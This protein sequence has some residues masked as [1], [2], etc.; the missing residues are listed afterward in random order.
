MEYNNEQNQ[1]Q[2]DELFRWDINPHYSEEDYN[3]D[4]AKLMTFAKNTNAKTNIA[5]PDSWISMSARQHYR[6]FTP[7]EVARFLK[8]PRGYEKELRDL[9]RYLENTSPIYQGV[10]NYLSSIPVVAPVLIPNRMNLSTMK[11][12]YEKAMTYLAKLNLSYNLIQVYRTCLRYDV[13]YGMEFEGDE[14]ATGYYIRPINPDY[15]RISG[16]EYGAFTFEMDM[17]FF[18]KQENYDV[19]ITLLEEFDHYIPGFFTKAFNTYKRDP[20][21]RWVEIPGEN[22]ICIKLKAELDYCYPPYAGI[23]NDVQNIEDYKA[24]AK[25]AE[26][27]TN[28][29]IIGFKIPRFESAKQ[30]R[31]DAFAIKMSTATM[32]YELARDSIADSIGIFYS[33]MEWES[34]KFSDSS[35]NGR[36]KVKEATDQLYDSLGIS[37]LLFNSDNATTLK[38]SIKVDESVIFQLNKQISTWVTRKFT[39]KHKGTFRVR[40]LDV[41]TINQQEQYDKYIKGGQYGQPNHFYNSAIMGADPQELMAMNYLQNEVLDI[42]TKFIPMSSSNTQS[43]SATTNEGGAPTVEDSDSE[44]TI[45]NQEAGTNEEYNK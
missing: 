7:E 8:N 28:Y 26:E 2:T 20:R 13:F 16:V 45:R 27:Q 37:R 5:R 44:N 1:A 15:C 10:V 31:P 6:E 34:I 21:K 4:L 35:T 29:K 36:N 19:D 23:Y 25:V 3:R 43:G 18:Q 33:P 40:L 9:A 32:F 14:D 41:T 11:V 39:Y 17:T 30:E 12:Q 42:P 22:S 38:Y 24:L